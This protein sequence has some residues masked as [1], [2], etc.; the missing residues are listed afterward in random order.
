MKIPFEI[1][2]SLPEEIITSIILF[3][4]SLSLFSSKFKQK[5][6][7]VQRF[8]KDFTKLC[9]CIFT[10]HVS[11]GILGFVQFSLESALVFTPVKALFMAFFISNAAWSEWNFTLKLNLM[12]VVFPSLASNFESDRTELIKRMYLHHYQNNWSILRH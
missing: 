4:N 6:Q 11:C 8:T 5:M 2:L 1:W 7:N 9:E 10:F 3:H 12:L